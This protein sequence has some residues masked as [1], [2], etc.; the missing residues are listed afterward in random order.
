MPAARRAA[1]DD[2]MPCGCGHANR[3]HQHY[4]KGTD[5]ALC[6]CPRFTAARAGERRGFRLL[7]RP[8]SAAA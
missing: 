4:R 8:R 6:V 7:R 5:C 1:S 2:D 3:A